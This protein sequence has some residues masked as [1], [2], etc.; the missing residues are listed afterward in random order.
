MKPVTHMSYASNI[1]LS[2]MLCAKCTAETLHKGGRC[3]HCDERQA[4]AKRPRMSLPEADARN[5]KIR[6]ARRIGLRP[7]RVLA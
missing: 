1:G 2:R 7:M 5:A 3:V 6:D 4:I